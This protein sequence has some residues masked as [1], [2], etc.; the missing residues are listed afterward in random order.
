[1]KFEEFLADWLP[2]QKSQV[3][4]KIK[5]ES[6]LEIKIEDDIEFNKSVCLWSNGDD[7]NNEKEV[8]SA[9]E[10]IVNHGE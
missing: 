3:I 10:N 8:I 9:G 1:M 2:L 5:V 7:E 6:F 4:G